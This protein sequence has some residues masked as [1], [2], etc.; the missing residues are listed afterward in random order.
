MKQIANIILILTFLLSVTSCVKEKA[1]DIAK[2]A[3]TFEDI[4]VPE[5]FDY[6]STKTVTVTVKVIDPE[7]LTVYK[8]V[9]IIYDKAPSEGGK[10][11]MT[12]AVNTEDYT[13]SPNITVPTSATQVWVEIY[14][15]SKLTREGYQSL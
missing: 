14:L 9:V 10:L 3:T 7:V 4:N 8:Y 13:Y 2:K 11:L 15:G 1:E 12:G 6:S 5:N